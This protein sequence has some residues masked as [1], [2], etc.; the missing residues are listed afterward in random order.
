[1]A[2]SFNELE[3]RSA[4]I[5]ALKK[6]GIV[7]PTKVQAKAIPLILENKDVIAQSQTGSGKTLAYLLPLFEKIAQ[8][9]REN[10]VIVLAPTHE[11]VMQIDKQIKLLSENSGMTISSAAIIGEANINNQIEKLKQKPHII[12][13]SAGR[14]L[15]LIKKKKI[16][17]HTVKSIVIDEGDRLLDQNNITIVKDIIKTTLKDR[18][19]MLFSATVNDKTLKIAEELM[20]TPEILK[21]E[22]ENLINPN[23]KHIYFQCEQRSKVDMLRKLI[24]SIKPKSALVFINKSDEVEILTSKLRYHSINAYSLLGNASKEDRKNAL[25]GFRLGKIQL[26]I[27]SDIAARGLDIKGVTHVFNLDLP[28]DPQQY[29]HR[30]GRTGRAGKS[31]IAISIVTEKELTYIKKYERDFNIKIEA[32]EVYGGVIIDKGSERP[33]IKNNFSNK[34]FSKGKKKF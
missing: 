5:E 34:S 16:S 3:L 29:L 9:K 15:E 22:E 6:E 27:A 8:D 20:K 23:I 28:E 31:G 10:Q 4:L 17:A 21:I 25:E 30:S 14:V 12:V 19:L 33:V 1:M 2:T 18:Q 26:L 32:K 11:L 24:A 13:G 7:E